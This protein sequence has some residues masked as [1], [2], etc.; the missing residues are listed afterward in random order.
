MAEPSD[1]TSTRKPEVHII[2]PDEQIILRPTPYTLGIVEGVRRVLQAAFG[3]A[4]SLIGGLRRGRP[5]KYDRAA[6]AAVA[7][8]VAGEDVD[9]TVSEYI[10][11]VIDR[12]ETREMPVPGATVMREICTP[13]YNRV[14][15]GRE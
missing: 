11:W 9:G 2:G 14:R 3:A 4:G 8:E 5:P 1:E 6:I 15:F 13:I 10:E 12:L 7:E